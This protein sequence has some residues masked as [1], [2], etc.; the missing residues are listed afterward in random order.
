MALDLRPLTLGELLD[1]SFTLYRRHFGLFVGLMAIPSVFTLLITLGSEVLKSMLQRNPER[2]ANADPITI[3]LAFGAGTVAF[4]L[5]F[6]GYWVAYMVALG[7]TTLAVSEIYVGR[8]T[9]IA[10]AYG[11][12][13]GQIGRL[14]LLVVL[15]GLRLLGIFLA[16]G[17]VVFLLA[18]AASLAVG[19][20]AGSVL[21]GAAGALGL[22]VTMAIVAVCSLRYSVA[23]P[24]LVLENAPANESI[25]R[26][27]ELTRGSLGR[28]AA[29][30]VFAIVITYA[31]MLL[32]QGPFAIGAVVAGPDTTAALWF[33]LLGAVTGTIG[34]A[35][36]GPLMIIALALLYYDVRI[37]KEG[38][39]LQLMLASLDQ[40]SPA[41]APAG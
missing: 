33:G 41:P 13:R 24:T 11:R 14:L 30:V 19:G 17:F 35:I 40:D 5:V 4:V 27:I 20:P 3:A 8:T 22:L 29:L 37:R 38:L 26:S 15:I 21:A 9:T 28:A 2:F 7:A 31:A 36:T 1:R 39:D 23:V 12:M 32:L 18:S 10:T 25:R 34:G 6:I 16:G